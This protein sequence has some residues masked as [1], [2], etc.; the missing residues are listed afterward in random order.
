MFVVDL[1]H[2]LDMPAD[3]PGPARRMADNLTRIV[4]AAT[5]GD[6]GVPWVSAL[7][8]SRRPGRRPCPGHLA[9]RRTEVPPSIEW[10]C[11]SCGD[12]G[13]IR[14]WERS[15]FD[16]RPRGGVPDSVAPVHAVISPAVTA[17]LRALML[18]DTAAERLVFGAT[19]S[20]EGVVLNG[21]EDAF[22][23]L[24]D[25]LAAA[26][27]HEADGRQRRRFDLAFEAVT[28]ALSQ[29]PRP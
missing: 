10:R 8:C 24:L 18:L 17:T 28:G 3:V 6:A 2:F 21:D 19:V 9:L 4:R 16:L 5:A 15:P 12:E 27:N 11:T 22:E 29:A 20:D 14:G 26:A 7:P 23:E 13:I 1:R 25:G